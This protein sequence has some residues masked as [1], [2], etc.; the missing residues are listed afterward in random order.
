MRPLVL[1]LLLSLGMPHVGQAGC[2]PNQWV[3]TTILPDGRVLVCTILI[4]LDCSVV[5]S[6][7]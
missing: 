7:V 1:A 2:Q 6:C 5:R 3:E 4:Q